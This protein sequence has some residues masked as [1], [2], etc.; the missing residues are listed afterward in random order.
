M[1]FLPAD[2]NQSVPGEYVIKCCSCG[3]EV[4]RLDH[5]EILDFLQY[6]TR[7]CEPVLCFECEKD[8]QLSRATLKNF[9]DRIVPSPLSS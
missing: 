5:T 8:Y 1:S 4:G 2:A 6:L 3:K 7:T 9:R